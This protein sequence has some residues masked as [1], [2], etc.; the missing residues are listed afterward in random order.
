MLVLKSHEIL[1]PE[2]IFHL[3]KDIIGNGIFSLAKYPSGISSDVIITDTILYVSGL[4]IS[5]INLS[6]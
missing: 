1:L 6:G 2:Y 4:L 3:M 5:L